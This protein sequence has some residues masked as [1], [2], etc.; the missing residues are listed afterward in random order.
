MDVALTMTMF[1]AAFVPNV[2][3]EPVVK[4]VPVMDT[5]VPPAVGPLF[6]VMPVTVGAGAR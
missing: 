5:A 4:F 6:G 1:V 2:T 3:V